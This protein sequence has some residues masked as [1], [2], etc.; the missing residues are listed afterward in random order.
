MTQVRPETTALS[1]NG[2]SY[3]AARRCLRHGEQCYR[4]VSCVS[5]TG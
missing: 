2:I 1:M 5:Q 3:T 4:T